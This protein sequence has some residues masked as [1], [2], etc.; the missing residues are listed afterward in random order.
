[1]RLKARLG[2]KQWPGN[3]ATYTVQTKQ[4]FIDCWFLSLPQFASELVD[5]VCTLMG[6]VLS[7]LQRLTEMQV[8]GARIWLVFKYN[9]GKV[10]CE[11][12]SNNCK[13][14]GGSI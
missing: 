7:F 2:M 12:S 14:S 11:L 1:M 6:A 9:Q 13:E 3:E 4:L 8:R 10:D 5:K